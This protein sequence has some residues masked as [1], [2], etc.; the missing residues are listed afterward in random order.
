MVRPL[1]AALAGLCLLA[2]PASS[3][4][5]QDK[6][7][8]AYELIYDDV[9]ALKLQ[10]QKLQTRS[11]Q[12]AQDLASILEQVRQL[13]D[14]VRR[15]QAEQAGL[16]DDLRAVPTQYQVLVQRLDQLSLQLAKVSSDLDALRGAAPGT[17]GQAPGAGAAPPAG[18]TTAPPE[19]KSAETAAETPPSPANPPPAG[20]PAASPQ[21]VYNAA[22]NDYLKG[23]Y[24]LAIQGF[25][26]YRQQFP[27]TPLADN[28]LYWIGECYFSQRQ[29]EEAINQ[30]NEVILLYPQGDKAAAAYLKK[31][32]SYMELGRK[33]EALAAFKLLVSK[34]P[35][36]DE[37]RIAQEKIKEIAGT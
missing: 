37:A 6:S 8:K 2:G 30:F 25:Q 22:Y 12:A 35:Q 15:G 18:G 29:F 31:G 33:D 14:L 23:N 1:A 7:K 26:Q 20:A 24:D 17:A 27:E 4:P 3:A 9:Q 21:D 16:R 11:D 5:P 34:H 36:T 19:K 28:A 32:M 13:A 10:V